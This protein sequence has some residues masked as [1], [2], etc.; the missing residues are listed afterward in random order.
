MFPVIYRLGLLCLLLLAAWLTACERTVREPAEVSGPAPLPSTTPLGLAMQEGSPT[1]AAY[2]AP[3][4]GSSPTPAP[5]PVAPHTPRPPAHTPAGLS[6][7]LYLPA[8]VNPAGTPTPTITPTPTATNTP[9]P[10]PTPTIDFRALRAEVKASGREL[11]YVKIGFHTGPGGN[12]TGIGEWMHRLDAA[13]VPFFL[14]SVD[15]SSALLEAQEILRN[16]DIPHVLVYR[17][18]GNSYDVP[19]YSL[20][21]A[22][23]A[24]QHWE[25]AKAAFPPELD[26]SL[27]WLETINEVDQNLGAWLGD[28]A[29]TT[30]QLALADGYRWAAFGWASGEPETAV[31]ENPRMLAFLRLA[32]ANPDRLAV[33]LH[34]YSYLTGDIAHEYPFKVGRFLSLFSVADRHGI[35]RPT[36]LITEWGWAYDTVPP[37]GEALADVAWASALYAPYPEIKGAAIWYLGPGFAGIADQANALIKPVTEYA[38]GNYFILPNPGTPASVDPGQY[39]PL[40]PAE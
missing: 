7:E 17:T 9:A 28:F 22:D 25:Q 24:R 36:V 14:K 20:P 1:G 31:W 18:S 13:G 19:D 34:E 6:E 8:I 4:T 11:A 38:L 40:P 26:P 21:P 27:V 33:A 30:A 10:T 32:G 16:S 39:Y 29:V 2:P 37:A 12:Q 5:Y 35:P 15:S 23:A 3:E